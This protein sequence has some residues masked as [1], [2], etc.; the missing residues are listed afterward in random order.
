M[1]ERRETGLFM[2]S[3]RNKGGKAYKEIKGGVEK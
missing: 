2:E 1:K 3:A